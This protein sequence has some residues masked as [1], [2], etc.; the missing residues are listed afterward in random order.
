M[1]IRSEV[2]NPFDGKWLLGGQGAGAKEIGVAAEM[3][4]YEF[5]ES[6]SVDETFIESASV[7]ETRA[8]L[9]SLEKGASSACSPHL[10]S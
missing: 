4:D 5:I 6:A 2:S 8:V 1:R 7:D 3:I 9:Y 10:R